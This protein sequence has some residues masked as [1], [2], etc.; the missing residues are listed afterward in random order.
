MISEK[1]LIPSFFGAAGAAADGAAAGGGVLFFCAT[2]VFPSAHKK[3]KPAT[4]NKFCFLLICLILIVGFMFAKN[5]KV[6]SE[7][8]PIT[9]M[10]QSSL[11]G[12]Q[13]N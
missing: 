13:F 9:K 5:R 3:A 6:I 11:Q 7:K 10:L 1:G 2:A 4:A 8:P 12:Y